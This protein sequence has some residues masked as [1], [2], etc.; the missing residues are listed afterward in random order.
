MWDDLEDASV[1]VANPHARG[2]GP[3][4]MAVIGAARLAGAATTSIAGYLD[5]GP[6]GMPVEPLEK[7]P[8]F[9]I[10]HVTPK[11]VNKKDLHMPGSDNEMRIHFVFTDQEA[12]IQGGYHAHGSR[13]AVGEVLSKMK[14]SR[15]NSGAQKLADAAAFQAALVCDRVCIVAGG[16][17]NTST[18]KDEGMTNLSQSPSV[19]SLSRES[20]ESRFVFYKRVAGALDQATPAVPA[21]G[22][23]GGGGSYPSGA[24][25][26]P[27]PIDNQYGGGEDEQA[28]V[29]IAVRHTLFFGGDL[30]DW[31]EITRQHGMNTKAAE[32]TKMGESDGTIDGAI[33]GG[34]RNTLTLVNLRSAENSRTKPDDNGVSRVNGATAYEELVQTVLEVRTA[35][36]GPSWV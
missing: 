13:D 36:E 35:G 29:N 6:L 9:G 8:A 30:D 31:L 15:M 33:M 28:D 19:D 22:K 34:A 27:H 26:I 4:G 23:Q 10:R 18:G 1:F 20:G 24:L 3:G 11:V 12:R 21:A 7:E 16:V 5:L 25:S 17:G 2:S 14:E 32:N